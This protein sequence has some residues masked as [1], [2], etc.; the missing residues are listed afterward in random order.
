MSTEAIVIIGAVATVAAGFGGA[1][2]GATISYRYGI[3]LLQRQ[4]FNKAATEFRATFVDE[5]LRIGRRMETPHAIYGERLTDIAIA[6]KKAKIIFEAFLPSSMLSGFNTAW[7]K[8]IE[9]DIGKNS[10]LTEEGRKKI[11]TIYLSHIKNL[12]E[13]AKPKIEQHTTKG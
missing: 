11:V 8:Y 6:N 4:E 13:F 7:D 5:M 1:F 10:P 12:L 9:A 2:L 3:K